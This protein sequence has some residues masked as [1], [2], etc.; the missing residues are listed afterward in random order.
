MT[1]KADVAALSSKLGTALIN[2]DMAEL[3]RLQQEQQKA[4]LDAA[5]LAEQD[6]AKYDAFQMQRVELRLDQRMLKIYAQ[7]RAIDMA[8]AKAALDAAVQYGLSI[9]KDEKKRLIQRLPAP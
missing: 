2:K 8:R 3:D 5:A 9:N 1:M 6:K 7:Q 4:E